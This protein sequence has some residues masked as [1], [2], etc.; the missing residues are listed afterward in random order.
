VEKFVD[1]KNINKLIIPL[2]PEQACSLENYFTE[3]IVLP[4]DKAEFV[5]VISEEDLI[6]GYSISGTSWVSYGRF[7]KIQFSDME[8]AEIEMLLIGY[9]RQWLKNNDIGILDPTH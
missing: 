7:N 4:R 1:D 2:S 6:G 8:K 5:V 3:N 9:G